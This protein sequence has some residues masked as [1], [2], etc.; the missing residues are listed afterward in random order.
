M[1]LAIRNDPEPAHRQIL[2][3]WFAICPGKNE[4]DTSRLTPLNVVGLHHWSDAVNNAPAIG[5]PDDNTPSGVRFRNIKSSADANQ[6]AHPSLDVVA[7]ILGHIYTYK[8]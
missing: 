7:I 3:W 2:K 5:A 4:G 1:I 8:R 6:Q